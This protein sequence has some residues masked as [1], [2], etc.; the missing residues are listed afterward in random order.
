VKT[1]R[2]YIF[3]SYERGSFHYDVMVTLILVFIFV[4]P[5]FINFRDKP[6]P[7]IPSTSSEVLVRSAGTVG[8]DSRYVYTVRAEE[9][10]GATSDEDIR[11]GILSVVE[12]MAGYVRIQGYKPVTDAS[13]HL[14][15][16]E[17]TVLR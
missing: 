15:A 8:N 13:G 4:A 5:R 9:L 11:S 7:R 10:H 16:Y 1:L 14:I 6:I 17:A 12:P 2:N 3:W